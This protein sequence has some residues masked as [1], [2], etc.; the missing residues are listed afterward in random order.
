MLP[1]GIGLSNLLS[2]LGVVPFAAAVHLDCSE[3]VFQNTYRWL[4]ETYMSEIQEK[5]DPALNAQR[6]WD[7]VFRHPDLSAFE[8]LNGGRSFYTLLDGLTPEDAGILPAI[9]SAT[10]HQP[11]VLK[12]LDAAMPG[13]LAAAW[14]MFAGRLWNGQ[15]NP[16]FQL[17][18]GLTLT[19][20]SLLSPGQSG[21]FNTI[22][23]SGN[24]SKDYPLAE[25]VI[26]N[27]ATQFYDFKVVDAKFVEVNNVVGGNGSEIVRVRKGTHGS[28]A[29]GDWEEFDIGAEGDHGFCL[30]SGGQHIDEIVV[31]MSRADPNEGSASF[32]N[33]TLLTATSSCG[34]TGTATIDRKEGIEGGG[35]SGEL[36]IN[37]IGKDLV[38]NAVPVSTG[39]GPGQYYELKSGEI[40]WTASGSYNF[41]TGSCTFSGT[42][43]TNLQA[44]QGLLRIS[45]D[46]TKYALYGYSEVT[47]GVEQQCTNRDG[48]SDDRQIGIW[49]CSGGFQSMSG[50]EQIGGSFDF[51]GPGQSAPNCPVSSASV[52]ALQGNTRVY[53]WHLQ[54]TSTDHP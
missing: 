18:E 27:M 38:F 36:D 21:A 25:P 39:A 5:V 51:S 19:P 54:A 33:G 28:A 46:G 30:E 45:S 14:K 32:S 11:T 26:K 44:G 9:W 1:G 43:P 48:L 15:P 42:T 47:L 23:L 53:T 49:L 22:D 6:A 29:L 16:F 41:A 10:E 50:G 3:C 24:A 31:I 34:W 40:D 37:G 13:G 8:Q 4:V 20:A 2:S 12:A 35:R 52:A 7:V 17:H